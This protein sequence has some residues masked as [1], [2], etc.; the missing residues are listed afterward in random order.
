MVYDLWEVVGSA[1]AFL[2]MF[3]FLP[4]IFKAVKTK[5]IKDV[6]IFTLLQF[7]LGVFLWMLYGMHLKNIIMIVANVF[8]LL[9]IVIILFLYFYYRRPK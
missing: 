9:S 4:Q 7:A 3:A 1:A 5:S 6:S 8:T 2:T